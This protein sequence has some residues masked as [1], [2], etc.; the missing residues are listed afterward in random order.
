MLIYFGNNIYK[1]KSIQ[2]NNYVFFALIYVYIYPCICIYICSTAYYQYIPSEYRLMDITKDG[3]T[4]QLILRC[5]PVKVFREYLIESVCFHIPL[6]KKQWF[7][8]DYIG[9]LNEQVTTTF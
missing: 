9:K 6:Y 2:F 1:Y 7:G 8:H 3:D 5:L 4:N